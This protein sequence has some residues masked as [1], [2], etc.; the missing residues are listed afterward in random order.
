LTKAKE[1]MA[2]W[3]YDVASYQFDNTHADEWNATVSASLVLEGM[4]APVTVSVGFGEN[5]SITWASGSLAEPQRGADYPTVGAAKGLERLKD[6]PAM[7]GGPR[8]M[9]AGDVAASPAVG[10]PDVAPCESGLATDC[11]PISTEPVTVT[12]NTVKLD[13][14]MV[15]DADNTVWLLPAYTFGSADGGTYT[16][17]AVDDSFIKQPTPDVPVGEPT[18][19]PAP[20]PGEAPS[21]EDPAAVPTT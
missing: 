6:Q 10:A 4:K 9:A 18:P 16:V 2:S 13:L 8:M 5:G 21:G 14:T 11:A 15:W 20:V 3:G 12:M 17:M 7:Y 19:L 1:L